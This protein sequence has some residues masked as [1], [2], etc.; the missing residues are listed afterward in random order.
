M[1][2]LIKIAMVCLYSLVLVACASVPMSSSDVVWIDVRSA[3]EYQTEHL[4]GAINI[5]FTNILAGIREAGIAEDAEIML[6]CGSGRRAGIALTELENAG[7]SSV[8]NR[9]GLAD[10]LASPDI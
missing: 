7:Y 1:N 3:E 10:L 8:T 2:R 5:E 9:G 6:Y 4:P